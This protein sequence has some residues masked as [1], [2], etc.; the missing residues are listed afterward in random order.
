MSIPCNGKEYKVVEKL[1]TLYGNYNIRIPFGAPKLLIVSHFDREFLRWCYW[2]LKCMYYLVVHKIVGR[3][4]VDKDHQ[5]PPSDGSLD[6]HGF[7]P[8]A[9]GNGMERDERLFFLSTIAPFGC[10]YE[11]YKLIIFFN[12]VRFN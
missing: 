8:I 3:S 12:G 2:E 7:R 10:P 1:E 9:A 4:T 11:V 5:D 6:P